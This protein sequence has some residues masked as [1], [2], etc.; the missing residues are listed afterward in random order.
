[1]EDQIKLYFERFGAVKSVEIGEQSDSQTHFAL[2]EFKMVETAATV[3]S[4]N[5]IHYIDG[6]EIQIKA[7]EPCQQPDHF[8]NAL[9]NDCLRAIL[10][11]LNQDDL[12]NAANVCVQFN[13]LAKSIFTAKIKK[14]TLVF[15]EDD[16][17]NSEMSKKLLLTFGSVAQSI[18]LD[19]CSFSTEELEIEAIS[20]LTQCCTSKLTEL[21]LRNL[22]TDTQL[23]GITYDKSFCKLK[24]LSLENCMFSQMWIDTVLS[25]CN[26]LNLFEIHHCFIRE[27]DA[28]DMHTYT[29]IGY[30]YERQS[31][32]KDTENAEKENGQFKP[33]PLSQKRKS[34]NASSASGNSKKKRRLDDTMA[35]QTK[36]YECDFCE[37][38]TGHKP[39]LM[40][41]IRT[42]TGEQPFGCEICE[43]RFTRKGSLNI[44]MRQHKNMFKFLCPKCCEI[45]SYEKL[46]KLHEIICNTKKNGCH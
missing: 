32:E 43:K 1:M 44:H 38:S 9:N 45:L 29:L 25:A 10:S 23:I 33:T 30:K 20:M 28:L 41:H 42:H 6:S 12:T 26:E 22:T 24:K 46:W 11:H 39:Y 8:L 31:M 17:Y 36:R 40:D 3:L 13:Q 18:D 7:A 16:E 14:L 4:S 2:V 37:Y 5:G 19:I 27:L 34:D 21:A 35:H 15:D